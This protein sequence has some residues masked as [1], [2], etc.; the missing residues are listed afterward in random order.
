MQA[1][2][3]PGQV[4]CSDA[5]KKSEACSVDNMKSLVQ[6]VFDVHEYLKTSFFS[7]RA[8]CLL[9]ASLISTINGCYAIA[10]I[11]GI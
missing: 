5:L 7:L 8:S 11:D 9:G 10:P 2:N 3:N 4:E 1:G 6:H